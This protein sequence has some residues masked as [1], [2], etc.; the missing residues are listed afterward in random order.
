[1]SMVS[2]SNA[3]TIAS[4]TVATVVAWKLKQSNTLILLETYSL[5]KDKSQNR[6]SG[7]TLA[8]PRGQNGWKGGREQD[9][10]V[11]IYFQA[12]LK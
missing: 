5:L 4:L 10:E 6:T 2:I 8:T 9:G 11:W 7:F 12:F 1:M 3:V